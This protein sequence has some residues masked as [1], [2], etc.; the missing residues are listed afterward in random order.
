MIT[1]DAVKEELQ[2]HGHP[3]SRVMNTGI[4]RNFLE[5]KNEL[6]DHYRYA[7]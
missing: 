1:L 7:H 2:V 3:T 6:I 4:A 5:A